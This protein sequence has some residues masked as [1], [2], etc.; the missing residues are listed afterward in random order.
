MRV[1]KGELNTHVK[2]PNEKYN[3][4]LQGLISIFGD[5]WRNNGR[6]ICMKFWKKKRPRAG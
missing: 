3:Q 4:C 5:G 2:S 6:P 1:Y